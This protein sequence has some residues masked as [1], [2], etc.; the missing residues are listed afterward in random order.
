MQPD[1]VNSRV[2]SLP[3][4]PTWYQLY[5][6]AVVESDSNRALVQME[7]AQK[8]IQARLLELRKALPSSSCEMDDL[9]SALNYL[10]LLFESMQTP[11]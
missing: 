9:K 5:F 6:A 1:K 2:P 4:L 8:A 3:N 7:C 10:G 11:N